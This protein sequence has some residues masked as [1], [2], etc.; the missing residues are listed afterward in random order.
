M[1]EKEREKRR[2][3]RD[4]RRKD[5]IRHA[6]DLLKRRKKEKEKKR[7]KRLEVLEKRKHSVYWQRKGY[8]RYF[9]YS[10]FKRMAGQSN[11]RCKKDKINALDL[12]RLARKQKLMCAITGEKL[13]AENISLDHI[14][15]ISKGG[16]NHITNLQLVTRYSN[17]IKNS[18]DMNEFYLF[19]KNIVDR[20][21]PTISG[22]PVPLKI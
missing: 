10:P 8:D 12:W 19:C 13:N 18:M 1:T 5:P 17:T 7:L 16:T 2:R 14:I 21:T 11:T 22:V 3:Y 4:R 15:S 20:F 9:R 6:R